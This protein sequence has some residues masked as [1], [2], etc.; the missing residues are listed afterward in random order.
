MTYDNFTVNAQEA[1]LAGQRLAQSQEQTIVSHQHIMLGVMDTDAQLSEFLMQKMKLS[2]VM[3]KR[4]L[5][6]M[7]EKMPKGKPGEK[8]LLSAEANKMLSRSKRMIADWGDQYI[9]LEIMILSALNGEDEVATLFKNLGATEDALKAAIK[10]LRQG[11][12]VTNQNQ[13][14]NY[15]A[16]KKFGINLTEKARN[17]ELN[18]IIGRD[19][20]IRRIIHILSRKAKNNPILV[21]DAGVGKTAIV[22]GLAWRIVKQDVPENLKSK[23]IYTLD[24]ASLVAGA[25]YKGEFEERIKSIIEE[26][27]ASGGEVILFIDEIH[28]L[29]GAGGGNGAM[30]AANILKPALARGELLTIGATTPEEYQKYFESDK[31]LVRRFQNINIEEPSVEETISILRGVQEKYEVFHKIGIRDDALIAAVELSHRYITDRKLPD[32]AI[33]LIDEASSKLRL[34]LDSVPDEIDEMERKYQQML[35]EQAQLKQESNEKKLAELTNNIANAREK[36]DSIKAKWLTEKGIIDAIQNSKKKIDEFNKKAAKAESEG[37]NDEVAKIRIEGIKHEEELLSANEKL[38]DALGE[39]RLTSDAV[40]ADD[41]A[42]VVSKWTGIQ[43]QKMLQSDKSRLLKLEDEIGKRLIGQ[44]EAVTAVCDAVRRSRAGLQ[45]P[46]KP[47]GS[48]IF[49]GPTGVGKTEL[50]KALA[51]VL[52]DDENAITRIDMSE[53]QEKHSVA[54]LVGAPPGYV[55]YDEGGQLTESVRRRPYTIVLLDEIEKAHPDTFNILLQILDDGRLTDNKGRVA[56][57]KN[58]I[59]IMTSNMGSEI[60]LENF[61]DLAE[62]G[63]KHRDEILATTKKEVFEA[64][65]QNLKPEFLNRIDEKIMFLPLTYAEVKTI[66]GIMVKKVTKNLL[67]QGINIQYSENAMDLITKMGYDPQFG[68]RPLK[69]VIDKEVVNHLA[70]EVLAGDYKDGDTIYVGTDTKG[71]IFSKAPLKAEALPKDSEIKKDAITEEEKNLMD[72]KSATK[73]LQQTVKS[74]ED[75]KNTTP[76][77]NSPETKAKPDN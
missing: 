54:R 68:A 45:D 72:L 75:D 56:N 60:I 7:V 36:L 64:L 3:V 69:R 28:T 67:R 27:K 22:E 30:D 61:E 5:Y 13:T 17:G 20:E 38:L 53:Y 29:I 26:V 51:E 62:V 42:E 55:G 70:K 2:P 37:K 59:I 32:K 1:I 50:A 58:T 40:T 65:K 63:D 11:K 57:F 35:I 46:N 21:G 16:L 14:E 74:M 49:L 12:K 8:Q 44:K 24:L 10:E 76:K 15:Q 4:E 25:K 73:D 41:I 34:E 6:K 19:D 48:F 23:Q 66:A 43:V 39:N 31:A 47:V 52:F 33:D 77:S 18:P 9:S 71:F